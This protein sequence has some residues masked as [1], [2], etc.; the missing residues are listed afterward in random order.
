MAAHSDRSPQFVLLA[1]CL[2]KNVKSDSSRQRLEVCG[3]SVCSTPLHSTLQLQGQC[4]CRETA[5]LILCPEQL[6]IQNKL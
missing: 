2:G 5:R 1:C 6:T 4:Q 3:Q